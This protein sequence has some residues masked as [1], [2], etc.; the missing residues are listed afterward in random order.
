MNATGSASASA[1][2]SSRLAHHKRRKIVN[3]V[4]LTLSLSAM[5]FGLFWLIWILFETVRLGIGG[6]TWSIFS[7]MTP[8]PQADTGGLSNAI[9]GSLMMVSLAT[10]L[11]TPIGVMAGIY[12]AEYGQKTWLGSTVRFINDILLS[13]PSIVIGL[14][15]YTVVVAPMKG[16]SG[17]AG[18]LALALIVIPVVIRTTENMLSLIPNAL[19]EAAYAL[20]TPKWKVIGKITLKSARAGVLTG[21]LLAV[22]R[23][24]GETAPL[25]FTALSNQF[26]TSSLGEPM[27]SLP[28]TIFKFAMS[29]YENWQKLAWAGVFLITLGVLALNI[30]ARVLFRNKN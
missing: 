25:L 3:A 9:F 2:H 17:F 29:P 5:A 19:R 27:A 11:G 4:A 14:F 21:V 10:V 24:S 28:V 18:V 26:W 7:E 30:A 15:I 13:A 1:L 8:P 6:L 22:A 23:I 12:L 16:F 20:G